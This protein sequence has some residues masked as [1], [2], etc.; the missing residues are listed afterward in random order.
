MRY[1]PLAFVALLV[2]CGG[3]GGGKDTPP[4]VIKSFKY[5]D[6]APSATAWR[7]VKVSQ[8][9]DSIT[10]GLESPPEARSITGLAATYS[11][12]SGYS[13]TASA[14]PVWPLGSLV[15]SNGGST[16]GAAT[17]AGQAL[18]AS[19]KV[20]STVTVTRGSGGP[21]NLKLVLAYTYSASSQVE[22]NGVNVGTLSYE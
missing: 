16:V 6:P 12:S 21:V 9:A 8:T 5:T 1:A 11:A 18:D 22:K 20:L 13:L 14:L 7:V 17:L 19:G 4:P 3:G 15:S 10:L 2:A